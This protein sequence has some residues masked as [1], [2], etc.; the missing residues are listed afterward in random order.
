MKDKIKHKVF[1]AETLSLYNGQNGQPA[2]V[3]IDGLVYDVSTAFIEG[4]HINHQAGMDLSEDFHS[5][6]AI[7]I[8]KKY[9]IMGI[10]KS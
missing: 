9:P 7:E 5:I 6:H 1:T 4:A 3:A 8:I 10:Y 2:Y